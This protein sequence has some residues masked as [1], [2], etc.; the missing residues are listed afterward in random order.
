MFSCARR[1]NRACRLLRGGMLDLASRVLIFSTVTIRILANLLKN[2]KFTLK[3]QNFPTFYSEKSH[4]Y[5][6]PVERLGDWPSLWLPNRQVR[7]KR[8]RGP[9]QVTSMILDHRQFFPPS[10]VNIINTSCAGIKEQF[11]IWPGMGK[12]HC[13]QLLPCACNMCTNDLYIQH[14]LIPT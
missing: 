6:G 11:F 12:R 1:E 4:Y 3:N 10:F 7:V 8:N 9:C 14:A 13:E 5:G 2:L